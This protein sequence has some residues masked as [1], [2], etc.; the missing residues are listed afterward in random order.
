[1]N[2][3]CL[4]GIR[5]TQHQELSNKHGWFTTNLVVNTL[6]WNA[7]GSVSCT[8]LWFSDPTW[9]HDWSFVVFLL[10]QALSGAPAIYVLLC[11]NIVTI[12]ISLA[13]IIL[14]FIVT[15]MLVSGIALDKKGNNRWPFRVVCSFFASY[16]IT[17]PTVL[18]MS[19]MLMQRRDLMTNMV[20]GM[21]GVCVSIGC[22]T[23]MY[24]NVIDYTT[25]KEEMRGCKLHSNVQ[26]SV[27]ICNAIVLASL[28]N[29]ALPVFPSTPFSNAAGSIWFVL[30]IMMGIPLLYLNPF[31]SSNKK[32]MASESIECATLERMSLIYKLEFVARLVFTISIM[33]DV[34]SV[35]TADSVTMI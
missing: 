11:D 30:P 34:V 5:P 23:S 16:T 19:N 10:S 21:V 28:Y 15:Q 33:M 7:I 2:S 35:T 1:M 9:R 3:R 26:Y 31:L 6:V 22:I 17:L 12:I 32:H 13:L 27:W 24:S 20:F 29:L 8:V 14:H 4:K 18:I 25:K